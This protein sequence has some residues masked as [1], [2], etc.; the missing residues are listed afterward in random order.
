MES[1]VFEELMPLVYPHLRQ[2]A[3]ADILRETPTCSKP[4]LSYTNFT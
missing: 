3:A 1:S 4:T 2:A